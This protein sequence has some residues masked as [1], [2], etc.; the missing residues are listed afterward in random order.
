M[1]LQALQVAK[2]NTAFVQNAAVRFSDGGF[3]FK[4]GKIEIEGKICEFVVE[5][6]SVS[7][8]NEEDLKRNNNSAFR[9]C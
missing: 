1:Q 8:Y 5:K 3:L 2:Y 9:K 4:V 7:H 6:M